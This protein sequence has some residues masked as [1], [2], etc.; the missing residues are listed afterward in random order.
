MNTSQQIFISG[1]NG[2]VGSAIYR[3]LKQ[4]GYTNLLTRDR[5]NLDLMDKK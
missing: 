2:M 5:K 4:Q 3:A 1:H